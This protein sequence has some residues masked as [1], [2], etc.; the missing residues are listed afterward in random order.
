VAFV[1]RADFVDRM[2]AV[3]FTG[4]EICPVEIVK[5]ATLGRRAP[6]GN[7]EPEDQILK[8]K[9]VIERV[10]GDLPAL[11]GVI[12]TG[13]LEVELRSDVPGRKVRIQP[14]TFRLP[15]SCD[16]FHASRAGKLY[17]GHLFCTRRFADLVDPVTDNV[18]LT[19]FEEW[20]AAMGS[21]S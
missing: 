10:R 1:A 19:P 2:T 18:E 17:G 16:L 12:A 20:M 11:L 4:F 8:A 13:R 3:G 15:P 14:Y 5:V 7:G 9:N 6:R 21:G